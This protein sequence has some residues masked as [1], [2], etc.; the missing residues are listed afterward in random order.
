MINDSSSNE[1][2]D[3]SVHLKFTSKMKK[4]LLIIAIC[5]F[6]TWAQAQSCDTVRI[7]PYVTNFS[8][9]LDCWT[10]SDSSTWTAALYQNTMPVAQVTVPNTRAQWLVSPP[11]Q[12]P[13]DTVGLQMDWLGAK[14]GSSQVNYYVLISTDDGLSWDTVTTWNYYANQTYLQ[15][16]WP[17]DLAPY[18]GQTIRV[19][20]C[21]PPTSGGQRMLYLAN[22][23]IHSDRM[24]WGS[25][26]I[27]ERIA[28][29]GDT[30]EYSYSLSTETDSL[31]TAD[32]HST[33]VAN[34]LATV[35]DTP[36]I[37]SYGDVLYRVRY[38]AAGIDTVTLTISNPFGT[39][40]T[41][42]HATIY[43]CQPINTFP[44]IDTFPYL[45]SY[46]VCWQM[47]NFVH[48]DPGTGIGSTDENGEH[49]TSTNHLQTISNTDRYLITPP[50]AVPNNVQDLA[51]SL[52]YWGNCSID[53]L[54]SLSAGT[55]LSLFTDTLATFPRGNA[56]R[57]RKVHLDQYA[58]QTIRLAL[59]VQY[60][61]IMRIFNAG[62]DYD[63]L[64]KID[65][66]TVPARIY[67]D[68]VVLCTA[69]LRYGSTT[70]L[71]Y[72]WLSARG[73][74][75]VTNALGDSAYV[76]AAGGSDYDTLTV[77]ATNAYGSDTLSQRVRVVDCSPAT[78]LPWLETFAD[79]LRCWYKPEGSNWFDN[80]PQYQSESARLLQSMCGSST[81]DSW[82]ISKAIAIPA[83]TALG[84][85]LFWDA[86]SNNNNFHFN[87]SVLATV[88]NHTDTN[89][90]I[91]LYVD[92]LT[93]THF[94]S[95][96]HMSISLAQFA[97]QTIHLAFR[98]QSPS[99]STTLYIDNVTVRPTA[100]PIINVSAPSLV[101]DDEV[102]YTATLIEGSSNGLS[103]T[104]HSSLM[105][106][107][108]VGDS[109]ITITYDTAGRDTV[110]VIAANLYGSDI[111]TTTTE[112]RRCAVRTVPWGEDF[113]SDS[114]RRC[115][116]G[117]SAYHLSG[118][119]AANVDSRLL[120]SPA[121]DMPANSGD[122]QLRWTQENPPTMGV[123]TLVLVSPTGS[124]DPA[125]FTDT[126]LAQLHNSGT[127]S[128]ILGNAYAGQRIR[129]AFGVRFPNSGEYMLLSNVNVNY[130]STAPQISLSA[131]DAVMLNDS[132]LFAATTNTCS[133]SGM[134]CSWHSSL[135]DTT[136]IT[137]SP[138]LYM[139]YHRG[140]Y[141]TLTLV[142][143]ND[144]GADTA[145]VTFYVVN[146]NGAALPYTEDF[147]DITPTAWNATGN[148]PVC[149]EA[150]SNGTAVVNMPHVVNSYTYIS[151]IPNNALLMIA[152]STTGYSTSVQ[153]VLPRF[154]RPM[155]QLSIAF[156]YQFESAS[157]GTLI[158]GYWSEGSDLFTPVDTLTPHADTYL[159]DTVSFVSAFDSNAHIALRWAKT[160]TWYGVA[161]DNIRVFDAVNG[162][163]QP[164]VEL[165]GPTAVN[166]YDTATFT[167]LLLDGDTTALTYTWH[168]SLLGISTTTS[169]PA[170]HLVYTLAGTDTL[171][172]T[173][174]NTYGSRSA[175]LIV[176]VAGLPQMS[177]LGPATVTSGDTA[178]YTAVFTSGADTATTYT[179]HSAMAA[180]GLAQ[181]S[182]LNSHLSILYTAGGT[183]TLALTTTT[184]LGSSTTTRIITVIGCPPISTFPYTEG[185][186]SGLPACWSR[187]C[188]STDANM[189][190][191]FNENYS[192]WCHTGNRCMVSQNLTYPNQNIADWL[193]MP[194][195]QV[196]ASGN[197]SLYF[198]VNF[199]GN[200]AGFAV[201]AST[202]G[203]GSTAYFTDTLFYES[204]HT[205]TG[206]NY[207]ATY[208]PRS[209][210]L[211]A[212]AGQ[213]LHLAFV[214]GSPSSL[215]FLDDVSID[216]IGL[217]EIGLTGP[218]TIRSCDS[219]VFQASLL[220]GDTTGLILTWHSAKASRGRAYASITDGRMAIDY[221]EGGRDTISVVA[222][223]AFGSDTARLYCT[224][225][226]CEPI[227]QFPY[228]TV[229]NST[230]SIICWD[231]RNYSGD[232]GFSAWRLS[233][234]YASSNNCMTSEVGWPNLTYDAWLIAQELEIPADTNSYTLQWHI[235]CDHA[236]Y[237]VLA[238]TT[239]RVTL[240]GFTDTLFSELRDTASWTTRSISLDAYRGQRL[241]IAF[242][243]TGW[244]NTLVNYCN[245]GVIRIDTV[246]VTTSLDTHTTP[247]PVRYLV[248][249]QSANDTMGIVNPSGIF[250]VDS[251]A[252]FTATA[253]A[254]EG[255]RFEG[256][257]LFPGYANI[258]TDNPL[259]ITVTSDLT[260]TAHFA[261][262][263]NAMPDTVWRTV[264]VNAVMWDGSQLPS[265]LSVTGE[266]IYADSSTVTLTAHYGSDPLFW[267]WITP[268]GDTL[269]DNPY[270]FLVTSDTLFTAV[271]GPTDIGID[272]TSA[273]P[274]VNLYPNPA[275]T[276]VT[277]VSASPAAV[278]LLDLQGREHGS[279]QVV[280]GRNSL[281]LSHCPSGVYFVR[282]ASPQ[283]VTIRK[284]IIN[285]Q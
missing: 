164:Y 268:S 66:L 70:N 236:S 172:V 28:Q 16:A 185:F 155:Q 149:W 170:L 162:E 207:R 47:S 280:V 3:V 224:I 55:D 20:F 231:S 103:Y 267:Y 99:G 237:Q 114:T 86:A 210:S 276:F 138:T 57:V 91:P 98:N 233:N 221:Y 144:Y 158:V 255:Y 110:S 215:V 29:V 131:P 278:T 218:A 245:T 30:V 9:N 143:R 133:Q 1:K 157:Q 142:V 92:T 204:N 191:W 271:F 72:T 14:S 50:I 225:T 87:Y 118:G 196:P 178:F 32:W 150:M 216:I 65:A 262:D 242:R 264:R 89:S 174:T 95:F 97:G 120:I 180:R 198:W 227:S 68:S 252:L 284:L 24:P 249:L 232:G 205:H 121:I 183:D 107:T 77:I 22:L 188:A 7:F 171:T 160:G 127:D 214:H 58:G 113:S 229:L 192:S 212:Y 152:G 17:V 41:D 250:E 261:P 283:G 206:N 238:S 139:V 222:T 62:V 182:T 74:T 25:W 265:G 248:T 79:G 274:L 208:V 136:F 117:L 147:Q 31:T 177:I 258:V 235:L 200:P 179:W 53:V 246:R 186:E 39:L 239:G 85:R 187:H 96:D 90:Y 81:L 240:D 154:A 63:T 140:G 135:L 228:T 67:N 167:A 156:D 168:S 184:L 132:I 217:P 122:V 15:N 78:T 4:V 11:L 269:H 44:W 163:L 35:V 102:T 141:D 19:A 254:K 33:M 71:H 64:P 115:W 69:S 270:S 73:A 5:I 146:C 105:D 88:G 36:V 60:G 23:D 275:T 247:N 199:V 190:A 195:V 153:T 38:N 134:V 211:S 193:M 75:I 123:N 119:W 203:R 243:T 244:N 94:S 59:M 148:I 80:V 226:D 272:N 101:Y 8:P 27:S 2:R 111:A 26:W 189:H 18:A 241:Y 48:N 56:R 209:V 116:A 151:N 106:T 93:H 40:I 43:D 257:N 112:V 6:G 124:T 54:A 251:A 42:A 13:N 169:A 253:T 100:A 125:D 104:W 202:T 128:V 51:F 234:Y 145:V 266:G 256:W 220:D 10:P 223:N 52:S 161:I 37:N 166:A 181:L 273:T 129:V 194:A 45:G 12:L 279:W 175:W 230:N 201:L 263:T 219:A 34:G 126:I 46:N 282:V 21:V 285:K 260:I 137:P 49:W 61:Y 109:T 76:T 277:I 159:R 108:F 130:N 176:S 259:S 197:A 84:V 82:I 213:T 83:D 281:D 165:H 173:A